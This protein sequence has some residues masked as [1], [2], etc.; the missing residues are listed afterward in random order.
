MLVAPFTQQIRTP[1]AWATFVTE[2]GGPPVRLLWV[3]I[4][5]GTLRTRLISRGLDRDSAKLVNYKEFIE[6]I[7][8][9]REPIV[10]HVTV[11]NRDGTGPM[12]DQL[13]V[14]LRFTA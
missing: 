6:R 7:G 14:V 10:P 9:E 1:V 4:D 13:R 3:R 2:L 5:A 12:S 8:P 11:D